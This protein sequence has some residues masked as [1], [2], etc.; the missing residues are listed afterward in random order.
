[1]ERKVDKPIH[2]QE[3]FKQLEK[4]SLEKAVN[5]LKKMMVDKM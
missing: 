4:K 5:V 3:C 1:G 2:K